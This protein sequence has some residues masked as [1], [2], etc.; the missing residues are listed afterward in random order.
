MRKKKQ[1]K[2][3]ITFKTICG[4]CG[5]DIRPKARFCVYCQLRIKNTGDIIRV[6]SE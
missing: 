3:R 4:R 2:G 5:N 6:R 1:H